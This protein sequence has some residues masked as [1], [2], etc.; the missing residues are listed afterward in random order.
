VCVVVWP[1]PDVV[2]P[3]VHDQAVI[4]EPGC[5]VDGP[6][7]NA[8]VRVPGINRN[9]NAAVGA[10]EPIVSDVGELVAD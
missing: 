7:S 9:V 4:V 6:A 10:P 3:N 1:V 2:S 8:T 5:A